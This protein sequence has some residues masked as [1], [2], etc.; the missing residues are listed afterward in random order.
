M[1]QQSLKVKE[2]QALPAAVALLGL[3]STVCEAG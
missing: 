3:P 2:P 1:L